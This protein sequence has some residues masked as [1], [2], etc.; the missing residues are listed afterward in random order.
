MK[1]A[2]K[3]ALQIAVPVFY[4]C[5]NNLDIIST[6]MSLYVWF[7]VFTIYAQYCADFGL[8]TKSIYQIR[9][10]SLVLIVAMFIL[11][12]YLME[13]SILLW[14][15]IPAQF[16]LIIWFARVQMLLSDE[17]AELRKEE[18]QK[19]DAIKEKIV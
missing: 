18:N 11:L 14:V 7:V 13:G 12:S 9:N 15:L 2:D 3:Q 6:M 5:K 8:S 1:K 4:A 19:M 10:G 16:L 17:L